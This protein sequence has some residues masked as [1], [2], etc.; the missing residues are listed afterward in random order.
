V[1]DAGV[2][3][4]YV[5]DAVFGL[6]DAPKEYAGEEGIITAFPR[7]LAGIVQRP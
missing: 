3:Q 5:P 4:V 6:C 1:Q 2:G 7:R